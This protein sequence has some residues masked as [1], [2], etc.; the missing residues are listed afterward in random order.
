[1][2]QG[3]RPPQPEA[4]TPRLRGCH[5]TPQ[6]LP[7]HAS[8]AANPTP[9]RLPPHA[10]EAATPRLRG[11][12]PHA[13]TLSPRVRRPGQAP[14]AITFAALVDACCKA[15]EVDRALELL[16]LMYRQLGHEPTSTTCLARVD[17]VHAPGLARAPHTAPTA[18]PPP[19]K[20]AAAPQVAPRPL[21]LGPPLGRPSR[22]GATRVPSFLPPGPGGAARGS[23]RRS[24]AVQPWRPRESRAQS[25]FRRARTGAPH[26]SRPARRRTSS[27]AGS[28]CCR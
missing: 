18:R 6:R 8:E 16:Q 28:R 5:P 9:Q 27:T 19:P 1:M 21:R 24:P 22:G 2:C 3:L 4:A 20:A 7:P 12:H 14:D 23:G 17:I 13:S 25:P 11:C 15:L 26:C 10:S